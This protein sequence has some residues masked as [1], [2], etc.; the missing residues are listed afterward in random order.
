VKVEHAGGNFRRLFRRLDSVEGACSNSGGSSF[1]HFG[2]VAAKLAVG[3]LCTV[4]ACGKSDRP[5]L[6]VI[7][8]DTLRADHLS[9]YGYPRPTSPRLDA[10]AH[11]AVLFEK[12][13]CQSP[14]TLPSH[15]SIF[16]GMHPRTHKTISHESRVNPD[17]VTLAEVLRDRGYTTGAFISSHVL[18]AKYGLDQGFQTYTP[19]HYAFN[20]RE[21][22]DAEED[23]TTDRALEWLRTNARSRFF[24]WIHWFHPHRA[25]N[26][27]PRYAAMFAPNYS[28]PATDQND[29]AMKVWRE[30][31][32]LP[33]DDIAYM[34]GLYDGEVAFSDA[35]VGR[36]LDELARLD[37]AG[38]TM[39][40]ITSDHGEILYEHEHYFGHD[41]A[42]YDECT[43]IP[44]VVGMPAAQAASR[45][46]PGLVQSIDMFP[47]VLEALGIPP[48][49]GVEGKSLM[50]MI[51]GAGDAATEFAFSET[52]PFPE[53]CPPR[54]AVRTEAAKLIWRQE[55]PAE[56]A[57]EF[58]DLAS[59]PGEK[60]NLYPAHPDAAG[61][62]RVL[63][64]WV[65]PGG[66]SPA[67]IPT[68]TESG[69]WKIL[70]S[71]GYVD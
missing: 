71:L 5:N 24:L 67:P 6:I 49:K 29:F 9:C 10:F 15:T 13:L 40:V 51:E 45:R 50:P 52:F 66:L 2:S 57:K 31:I 33:A 59:D 7:T 19:V 27:P 34:R 38:N 36:V 53:K 11:E 70:K 8:I 17:L 4:A 65:A 35:Q 37:L 44:L 69:R 18:D 16:T 32:D 55:P 26:P 14:E 48:P 60:Q 25:Y 54:H 46:V 22:R 12:V 62:D 61:L 63:S 58:Y 43:M 42:L 41:I 30:R 39:I 68:A 28:G 21:R 3:L 23:P 64:E 56:I 20:E 47:T 1:K